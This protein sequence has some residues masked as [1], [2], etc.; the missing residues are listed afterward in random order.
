MYTVARGRKIKSANYRTWQDAHA[1]ELAHQMRLAGA[2]QLGGKVHIRFRVER[3][4]KRRRDIDNLAKPM[5]DLLVKAGAI[6]DDSNTESLFLMWVP[7]DAKPAVV[8]C[9]IEEIQ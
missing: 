3:P 8:H 7:C 4:D 1:S 5:L 9:E 2:K 6:A